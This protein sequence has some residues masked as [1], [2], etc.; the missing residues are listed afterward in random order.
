MKRTLGFL[1]IIIIMLS[2]C[3]TEDV[4]S[5]ELRQP[6]TP[7][8]E[9]LGKG[10]IMWLPVLNDTFLVVEVEGMNLSGSEPEIIR[11]VFSLYRNRMRQET[12]LIQLPDDLMLLTA[13]L[14]EVHTARHYNRTWVLEFNEA[15]LNMPEADQ[16]HFLVGLTKTLIEGN[17]QTHHQT[18]F[19]STR[20]LADETEVGSF[21]VFH[22]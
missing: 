12:G 1:I 18:N 3:A 6:L 11:D 15:L 5:Y 8:A 4:T 19:T 14:Q 7:G 17:Q 10:Y 9:T 2:G 20:I 16:Q 13:T 22:T 21:N